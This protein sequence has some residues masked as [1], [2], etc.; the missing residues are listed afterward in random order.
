MLGLAAPRA[1]LADGKE[2]RVERAPTYYG[3]MSMTM[4]SQAG[5]GRIYGVDQ[6]AGSFRPRELL[7]RLR[8]PEGKK[9][10]SVTVN[11]RAWSDFDAAKEW[12][13]IA[14]PVE[15]RYTLTTSY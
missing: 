12:V 9:I 1:W 6:D 2:I 8:H 15:D 10:R 11:G 3:T 14:Q 13:R 5:S 7:V 4:A